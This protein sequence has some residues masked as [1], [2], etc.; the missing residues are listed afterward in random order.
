[1]LWLDLK[2]K[3]KLVLELTGK[4]STLESTIQ[5]YKNEVDKLKNQVQILNGMLDEFKNEVAEAE[6][7]DDLL[8]YADADKAHL[9]TVEEDC[10]D[11]ADDE[12]AA[13]VV[14]PETHEEEDAEYR[15]SQSVNAEYEEDVGCSVS[16]S[17]KTEYEEKKVIAE[18]KEEDAKK[19]AAEEQ[20]EED[21]KKKALQ[22]MEAD[23]DVAQTEEDDDI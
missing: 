13:F 7:V 12:W 17:V 16:P 14:Q 6:D 18:E 5:F 9:L 19:V 11:D 8:D 21:W 2:K 22:T 23:T 4:V 20:I 10:S 3:D 15:P 1:M